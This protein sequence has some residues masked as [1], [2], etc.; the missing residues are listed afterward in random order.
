MTSPVLKKRKIEKVGDRKPPGRI[1]L[2]TDYRK[3]EHKY[4]D[5]GTLWGVFDIDEFPFTPADVAELCGE[6]E[7]ECDDDLWNRWITIRDQWVKDRRLFGSFKNP[8]MFSNFERAVS[9]PS[10]KRLWDD[11]KQ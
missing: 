6:T 4:R 7:H 5:K 8:L 9:L 2:I 10:R 1:L 11:R 3:D